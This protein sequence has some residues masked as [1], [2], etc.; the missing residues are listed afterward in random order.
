MNI[1]PSTLEPVGKVD[2][3]VI[4]G[5]AGISNL[6]RVQD[7]FRNIRSG[8]VETDTIIFAAGERPAAPHELKAVENL[9]YRPGSTEFEQAVNALEDIGQVQFDDKVE[10]QPAAYGTNTPDNAIK[11][12]QVVVN[13]RLINV[14]VVEGSYDR[15][16]NDLLSGNPANRSITSETLH[17]VLPFL[18]NSGEPILIE[19]HDTW[20]KGQ[21]IVSQ[22][23]LGLEAHR[24]VIG[25]W[26]YKSDR[27]YLGEDGTPDI[28]AAQAVMDEMAKSY[29]NY[30]RLKIAA[31]NKL[32]SIR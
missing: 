17:A 1:L 9:G 16:R 6:I 3:A 26:A 8:A 2:A 10:S 5:A 7:T 19:S 25:A 15:D 13:D 22:E 31:L 18:P 30:V 29:F 23:I 4:F 20:G 28:L 14:I 11:R 32:Q 12:G 21:E 24:E 27:V